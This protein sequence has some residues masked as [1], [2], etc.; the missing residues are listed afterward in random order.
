MQLER[1]PRS[2]SVT[3]QPRRNLLTNLLIFDVVEDSNC[4][5][6]A[7]TAFSHVRSSPARSSLSAMSAT[8][9][10][11]GTE[12]GTVEISSH[13]ICSPVCRHLAVTTH[14][15]SRVRHTD[16]RAPLNTT[17]THTETHRHT[18][19]HTTHIHTYTNLSTTFRCLVLAHHGIDWH[20]ELG[21][22]FGEGAPET[23]ATSVE[24]SKRAN[25]PILKQGGSDKK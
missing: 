12:Y 8:S 21:F 13:S 2:T 24:S 17:H 14:T 3:A 4:V 22:D 11:R 7:T 23:A 15:H 18:H 6:S 25:F 9:Q 19:A 20:R 1:E 16:T 10:R 5:R